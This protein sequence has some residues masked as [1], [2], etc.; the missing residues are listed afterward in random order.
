MSRRVKKLVY[1]GVY[2]A[3]FVLV[4]FLV[5]AAAVNPDPSCFDKVL[6]QNE[7]EVDCGGVCGLCAL[8]IVQPL[9][10]ARIETTMVANGYRIALVELRNP[11]TLLAAAEFPYTVFAGLGE[12]L[13]QIE[14][15][16]TLYPG[17][18]QY[19]VL[20]NPKIVSSAQTVSV[21][22]FEIATSSVAWVGAEQAMKP[23]TQVRE[24][25]TEFDEQ[26]GILTVSGIMRND[27][28][29]GLRQATLSAIVRNHPGEFVGGS[30]T[31]LRDLRPEEERFFQ[32]TTPLRA[33]LGI[34]EIAEPRIVIEAFR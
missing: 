30:R 14:D 9:Q 33:G 4:I 1:G 24:L 31:L 13:W 29:F 20:I 27:N 12:S 6:N 18:I 23:A 15:V 25:K 5:Y 32:I 2:L 16:A 28:A 3:I 26:S 7:V 8:K 11:N 10:V 34:E 17:E 19:R 21:L 22:P